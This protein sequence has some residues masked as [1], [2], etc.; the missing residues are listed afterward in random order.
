MKEA[1]RLGTGV[2]GTGLGYA[3]ESWVTLG[4]PHRPH[5]ASGGKDPIMTETLET[6]PP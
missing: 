4:I 1:S 6:Q 5:W 2:W 3:T